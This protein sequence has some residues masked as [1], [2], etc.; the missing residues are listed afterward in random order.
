[1]R[2]R[3]RRRQLINDPSSPGSG[4]QRGWTT[5]AMTYMGCTENTLGYYAEINHTRNKYGTRIL[6]A[7]RFKTVWETIQCCL[8]S[9]EYEGFRPAD[10]PIFYVE[11]I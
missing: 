1:M 4:I 5:V 9:K 7:L 3:T 8:T 6:C 2:N 11:K 10:L